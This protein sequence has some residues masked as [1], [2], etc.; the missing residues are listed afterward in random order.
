MERLPLAVP[1]ALRVASSAMIDREFDALFTFLRLPGVPA[2][3]WMAEQ[4]LRPPVVNRKVWGGNRTWRGA[5]HQ[6]PLMTILRTAH[7]QHRNLIL[8]P[9]DLLRSPRAGWRS[10]WAAYVWCT[11]FSNLR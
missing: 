2:T 4:A 6:E 11:A 7:Q 5:R 9:T 10:R 3:D 1:T 8:I